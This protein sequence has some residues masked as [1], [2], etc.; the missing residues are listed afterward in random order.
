MPLRKLGE[1]GVPS[2]QDHLAEVDAFTEKL[3][4]RISMPGT[5]LDD[6]AIAISEAVNNAMVHGNRLDIKKKVNVRLYFCSSYL[7]I[8][9]QDEGKGFRP[10]KVP[11][12]REDENLLK[13]SGR[14]LLIMRHL[15]D[16]ISFKPV[17][18]GM[19]IIMDK[20]CPGGCRL[21]S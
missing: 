14:G 7:R 21:E 16:Q 4:R 10:E 17:K 13:A 9:V 12:P 5:D 3:I 20:Y 15:M 11:D 1:L 2:S 19:Q 18:S 8:V 6:I